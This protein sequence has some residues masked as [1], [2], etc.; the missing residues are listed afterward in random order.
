[1]EVKIWCLCSVSSTLSH[2]NLEQPFQTLQIKWEVN[3]FLKKSSCVFLPASFLHASF[4][5]RLSL[6]LL[7]RYDTANEY[8]ILDFRKYLPISSGCSLSLS[9]SCFSLFPLSFGVFRGWWGLFYHCCFFWSC[10]WYFYCFLVSDDVSAV[11]GPA[12][13]SFVVDSAAV[14]LARWFFF[15]VTRIRPS[16]VS[17]GWSPDSSAGLVVGLLFLSFVLLLS[18][19]LFAGCFC[20][21]NLARWPSCLQDQKIDR[22]LSTT[23]IICWSF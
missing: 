6:L 16:P 21:Q 22:L 10:R 5:V 23:T 4:C 14:V 11:F 7:S 12:V 3:I 19:P 1:M 8:I 17:F 20:G 15:L 13:A 9:L 18:L 2:A